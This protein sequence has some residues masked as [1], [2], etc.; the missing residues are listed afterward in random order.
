MKYRNVTLL[1]SWVYILSN[2]F[3]SK[4]SKAFI[5]YIYHPNT[6]E[7][8]FTSKSIGQTAVQLIRYGQTKEAINLLELA[9]T[10]NPKETELWILLA[11]AQIQVAQNENAMFSLEKAIEINPKKANSWLSISSIY[12][13]T[14]KPDKAIIYAKKSIVLNNNNPNAYFILGNGYLMMNKLNI[15][16]DSFQKA[17][18]IKPDFWQAINNEGLILYELG[19]KESAIKKWKDAIS[20]NENAEPILALATALYEKNKNNVYAIELAQKALVLNPKYINEQFQKE[21]LWGKNLRSSTKNLLKNPQLIK[22]SQT[23]NP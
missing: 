14:K 8:H 22:S 23:Q 2:L 17:S 1:L 18:K 6:K 3:L 21:Q 9:I 13:K 4:P 15:S 20:I 19:Q 11:D 10:L 12:L 7:L 5:P 16:L